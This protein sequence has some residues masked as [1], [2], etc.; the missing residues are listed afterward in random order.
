M[1]VVLIQIVRSSVSMFAFVIT[2]S[3]QTQMMREISFL[4]LDIMT[5][6]FVF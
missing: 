3:H 2:F 1:I 5:Y 4:L 6:V